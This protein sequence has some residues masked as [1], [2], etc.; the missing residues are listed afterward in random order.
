MNST[1]PASISF[2]DFLADADT[3]DL[4]LWHGS[5]STSWAIELW[6][7]G[8][9]SHASM[10]I[11]LPS[12]QKCLW[13]A[14]GEVVEVD[15]VRG[16]LHTGAQLG[17]L[18][19]TV[20]HVYHHWNDVPYYRP[21]RWNRPVGLASQ[22]LTFIHGIDG[23]PFPA[24]ALEMALDLEIGVHLGL[25]LTSGPMF[26]SELVA[27]T[28]QS[29]QL[30]PPKPVANSYSPNDFSSVWGSTTPLQGSWGTDVV[31]DLATLPPAPTDPT[32]PTDS[33]ATG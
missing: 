32:D 33:T 19:A 2:T 29:M 21:L 11:V 6:T 18:A 10:V 22:L 3:G 17:D 13:Q 9:F 27:F 16:N 28:L 30:L 23:R 20:P 1:P 31:I 26:C 5:A 24:T 4:V 15:P 8:W 14:A 12:A 7:G 25:D